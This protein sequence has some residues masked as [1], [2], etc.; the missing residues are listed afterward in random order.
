MAKHYL[1]VNDLSRDDLYNLL[2]HSAEL[3]AE[4]KAG[5]DHSHLL[6]GKSV[7]MICFVFS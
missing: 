1:S 5:R 6:K 2:N 4:L 3:K 7:G